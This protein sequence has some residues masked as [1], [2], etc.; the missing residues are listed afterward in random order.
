M[1]LSDSFPEAKMK[2]RM[3]EWLQLVREVAN[4]GKSRGV[5]INSIL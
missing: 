4:L 1:K 2:Q 3:K 5:D